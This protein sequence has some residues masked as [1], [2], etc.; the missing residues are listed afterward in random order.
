MVPPAQADALSEALAVLA[1]P[2]DELWT[3]YLGL[4]GDLHLAEVEAFLDGRR[5]LAPGDYD[6]LV[7]VANEEFMERG[8]DHPLP[9]AD[10]LDRASEEEAGEARPGR[11]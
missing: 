5:S 2:V 8:Q 4:G 3:S 7:Q 1:I 6:R 9:Y 11:G 10:E